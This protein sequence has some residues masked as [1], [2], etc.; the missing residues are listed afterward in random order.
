MPVTERRERRRLALRESIVEAART[1]VRDDGLHALT[2]RR[3]AEAIDYAPASLYAH[4]ESREALLAELCG[5]GF[6]ALRGALESAIEGVAEPRARLERLGLAYVRFALEN[7][8]TYR[9]IFMEDTALTKGVFEK[10]GSDDGERALGLIVAPLAELR[11]AGVLRKSAD[12]MR[13][14]DLLWTIVHGIASLRLACPTLP[15]TDDAT[16]IATAI[17]TI[18]DGWR[19]RAPAR[20]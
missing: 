11:A 9:L 5:E 6:A 17:A 8:A 3:I 12:P 20:R 2:M 4:F 1:I 18:V 13:L 7:P 14:A 19:P 15:A 16:L 10:I